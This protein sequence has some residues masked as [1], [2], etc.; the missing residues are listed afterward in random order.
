[1]RTLEAY[2]PPALFSLH[3]D[4]DDP[5]I[6]LS[7]F[8]DDSRRSWRKAESEGQHLPECFVGMDYQAYQTIIERF[9]LEGLISPDEVWRLSPKELIELRRERELVEQLERLEVIS[10]TLGCRL[11]AEHYS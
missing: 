7:V 3:Y 9:G 11:P 4:G 10:D 6:T 1:M 2:A 8:W 5:Y